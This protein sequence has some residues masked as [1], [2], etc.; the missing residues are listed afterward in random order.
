VIANAR[1]NVNRVAL[2]RDKEKVKHFYLYTDQNQAN[3][4]QL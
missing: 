1:G 4:G 3:P 2:G